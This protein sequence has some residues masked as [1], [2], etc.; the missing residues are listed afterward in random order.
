MQSKGLSRVFSNTTVQKHQFFGP[1][2]HRQF[3]PESVFCSMA[4]VGVNTEKKSNPLP[5]RNMHTPG[6]LYHSRR[7]ADSPG[8]VSS[9]AQGGA[10]ISWQT[11]PSE[12]S[13]NL[14]ISSQRHQGNP[15]TCWTHHTIPMGP[16]VGYAGRGFREKRKRQ[17]LRKSKVRGQVTREGPLVQ[18]GS[19]PQ[20]T[21]SCT[22]I[23]N[24]PQA[25]GQP[26][27]SLPTF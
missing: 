20:A 25:P 13:Q 4:P 27:P 11:L 7:A 14:G 3:L 26:L 1:S 22:P 15:V 12:K 23:Q 10:G 8:T 17:E 16:Q 5:A 19:S 21:P 2:R 24:C 6:T 9:L 18:W